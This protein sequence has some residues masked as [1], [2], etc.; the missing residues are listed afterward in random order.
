M[1]AST[2]PDLQFHVSSLAGCKVRD[3]ALSKNFAVKLFGGSR[4]HS[5][6][7]VSCPD[8]FALHNSSTEN[9]YRYRFWSILRLS[10]V[11]TI[12]KA[13]RPTSTFFSFLLIWTR[14]LMPCFNSFFVKS[15]STWLLTFISSHLSIQW[16]FLAHQ[17]ILFTNFAYCILTKACSI[18]TACRHL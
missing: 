10:S 12:L 11:L 15:A 8:P 2:L 1:G 3:H 14:K 17:L 5:C 18:I 4:L 6:Y 13:H 9:W 7:C 16:D